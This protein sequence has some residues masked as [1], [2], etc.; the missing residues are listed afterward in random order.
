M[1]LYFICSCFLLASN[2][3]FGELE[4]EKVWVGI[5]NKYSLDSNSAGKVRNFRI[6]PS[7]T[8]FT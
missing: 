5:V 8:A 3:S 1:V 4:R 6:W 7:E 2:N